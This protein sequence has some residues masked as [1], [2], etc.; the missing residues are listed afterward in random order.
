MSDKNYEIVLTSTPHGLV[1]GDL[2]EVPGQAWDVQD[3]EGHGA[4]ARPAALSVADREA[5]GRVPH[6]VRRD[7]PGRRRPPPLRGVV[8]NELMRRPPL[9][10]LRRDINLAIFRSEVNGSIQLR[11]ASQLAWD[12]VTL[13]NLLRKWWYRA[14]WRWWLF[15]DLRRRDRNLKRR[16]TEHA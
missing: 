2:V 1:E 14:R 3:P 8:M 16:E 9:N 11:H 12:T 6:P 15:H 13:R 5:H 4:R 7:P 10:L